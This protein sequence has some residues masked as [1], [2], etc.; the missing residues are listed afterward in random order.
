MFQKGCKDL[1][2]ISRGFSGLSKRVLGVPEGL[3][4]LQGLKSVSKGFREVGESL[5]A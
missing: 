4:D 2:S 5:V 1:R 3:S